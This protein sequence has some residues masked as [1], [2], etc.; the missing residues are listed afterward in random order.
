[1]P[2]VT[3]TDAGFREARAEDA[4]FICERLASTFTDQSADDWRALFRTHWA[5]AGDDHGT[6]AV[7]EGRVVAFLGAIC[8]TRLVDG[9]RVPVCNLTSWWVDPSTRGTGIGGQL[10]ARYLAARRDRVI[11]LL[12]L[13]PSM[14]EF[15]R[16]Q[17]IVPMER[18]RRLI[19]AGQWLSVAPA[20]DLVER[21]LDE[22]E[23]ALGADARRI[24][25]DHASL[26]CRV[27]TFA[28]G[29]RT[30]GVITRR[31]SVRAPLPRWYSGFADLIRP[32]P[33]AGASSR[34]RLL[35]DRV[36]DLASGT[37]PCAEVL[38]V[39]DPDFMREWF[40]AVARRLCR[41]QRA[42]GIV[43]DAERIGLSS[44][45]GWTLPDEYWVIPSRE[46]GADTDALYSELFILPLGEE[47]RG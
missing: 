11:T 13:P 38:Y 44:R 1:M 2:E 26:R 25:R 41:A 32:S 46:A 36:R 7:V 17:G 40:P 29:G 19:L 12:T 33:G 39:S 4:D 5:D 45:L 34:L 14:M 30:C 31:R 47:S 22:A 21:P 9:R 20:R 42:L 10:V 27:T 3:R 8:S 16:R 43:G 37:F 24:L 6:V 23:G 15:W 28:A 35:V 18:S